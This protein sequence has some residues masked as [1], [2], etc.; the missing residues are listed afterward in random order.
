MPGWTTTY[1]NPSTRRCGRPPN[2]HLILR[3]CLRI[4]CAAGDA[5]DPPRDTDLTSPALAPSLPQQIQKVWERAG[6]KLSPVTPKTKRGGTD[7]RMSAEDHQQDPRVAG[8]TKLGPR[9][10]SDNRST[11]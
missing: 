6:G 10:R 9:A 8:G 4:S 3:F 1:A 11:L 7:W 2:R 5:I